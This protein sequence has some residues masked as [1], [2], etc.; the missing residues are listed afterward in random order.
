MQSINEK[1]WLQSRSF[2]STAENWNPN[3]G[4]KATATE[5]GLN[6]FWC[7]SYCF[8]CDSMDDS[9][10]A[11][12]WIVMVLLW[13]NETCS[14]PDIH[15]LAP[16]EGTGSK[17][18]LTWVLTFLLWTSETAAMWF[19]SRYSFV[20][21]LGM[22]LV[23]TRADLDLHASIMNEWNLFKLDLIWM[24][25]FLLRTNEARWKW[26]WSPDSCFDWECMRPVQTQ[27]NLDL[28]FRLW[29]IDVLTWP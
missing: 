28:K 3:P 27:T 8:H 13:M 21:W 6:W 11:L 2:L 18:F 22:Q 1:N 4:F 14:D 26:F 29:M 9:T 5:Q 24:I 19:G 20:L 7:Q 10:V 12:I 23:W 16:T 15:A 25:T 17:L